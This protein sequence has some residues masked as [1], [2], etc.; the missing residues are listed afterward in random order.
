MKKLVCLLFLLLLLAAGCGKEPEAS[1]APSTAPF[2][3]IRAEQLLSDRPEELRFFSVVDP[4]TKQVAVQ[5][6]EDASVKNTHDDLTEHSA[7]ITATIVAQ[8]N[9]Y[10]ASAKLQYCYDRLDDGTWQLRSCQIVE[11]VVYAV[12]T[13]PFLTTAAEAYPGYTLADTDFTGGEYRFHYRK[14]TSKPLCE[15]VEQRTVSANFADAVWTLRSE[16]SASAENWRLLGQ[17]GIDYRTWDGY[18]LQSEL[19][20]TD[21]NWAAQTISGTWHVRVTWLTNKLDDSVDFT[22]EPI[23][24]QGQSKFLLPQV[25]RYSA[26]FSEE[27]LSLEIDESEVRILTSLHALFDDG[28]YPMQRQVG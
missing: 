16:N 9:F 18:H 3:P 24:V 14:S 12:R 13:N 15:I 27:D 28:I 11:P 8:N 20:I 6:L 17:W 26:F 19:E 7:T 2:A 23:L 10:E 22:D 4:F 25:F 21:F 5:T 1:T